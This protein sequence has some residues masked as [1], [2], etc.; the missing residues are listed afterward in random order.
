M[1][2]AMMAKVA[3]EEQEQLARVAEQEQQELLSR[4]S[5]LREEQR[6]AHVVQGD[7][8]HALPVRNYRQ[9]FLKLTGS[10]FAVELSCCACVEIK[11]TRGN[12]GTFPPLELEPM[13]HI[14]VALMAQYMNVRQRK[15]GTIIIQIVHILQHDSANTGSLPVKDFVKHNPGYFQII[16]LGRSIVTPLYQW[17]RLFFLPLYLKN[18]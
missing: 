9:R 15:L 12:V 16:H 3:Q 18:E 2:D 1:E 6:Q 14:S 4:R 17:R 11:V 7:V 13:C 5:K 10:L 8:S